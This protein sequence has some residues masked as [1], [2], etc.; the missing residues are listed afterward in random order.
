[1]NRIKRKLALVAASALAASAL[2]PAVASAANFGSQVS[3]GFTRSPSD[4]FRGKVTSSKAS[5]YRNRKVAVYRRLNG[6]D[7]LMG[8]RTTDTTGAWRLLTSTPT[9]DYYAKAR[10]KTITS[11]TCTPAQSIVTHVS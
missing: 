5:C 11:G 4:R 3:I 2:A 9:G 6:P 7:H 1:M 10:A 8:T